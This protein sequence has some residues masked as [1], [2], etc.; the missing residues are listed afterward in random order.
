MEVGDP[1]AVAEDEDVA[2][3]LKAGRLRAFQHLPLVQD[4]ERVD[5]VRVAEL[6]HA[7]LAEG[8]A[9]NHLQDLEVVLAQPERFH[10]VRHRFY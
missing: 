3:L 9:A 5:P 2:F 8:P 4:L 10:A 1:P 6:D 7:D